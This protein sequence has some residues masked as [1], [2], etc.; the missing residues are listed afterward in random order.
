MS[1]PRRYDSVLLDIDG[2]LLYSNDE[3]AR[4]FLLAAEEMGIPVPEFELVR[5]L[6]GMGGDKLIPRVFG[7]GETSPQGQEL[8][9]RKGRIFRERLGPGLRPTPG[10][11]D[12]LVRLRDEGHTLVA[13]TSAGG[14]D[15]DLLL[16]KA[17]V[18]DLI[19]HHT[20]SSDVDESKPA[21]D[22]V[23][24]ALRRAG[25]TPGRAIMIGDTPY[26]V[27][28]AGRARV[29]ILGVRTG[30]WEATELQGA[31]AVY[32][33]PAAILAGYAIGPF[34]GGR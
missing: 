22:I 30:G 8:D 19:D 26:D 16:E 25:V 1:G 21:P 32:D 9:E 5:R 31:L 18:A 15:L 6:I 2:T 10:A 14:E 7:F 29:A 28:A 12:L 27:E 3:H 33:H 24:A 11:R 13:A 17:G 4:A 20:S 23:Q 34:G